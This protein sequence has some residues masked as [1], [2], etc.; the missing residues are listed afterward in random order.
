MIHEIRLLKI[1]ST[2]AAAYIICQ[3]KDYVPQEMA[4]MEN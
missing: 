3:Y 4:I 1:H 2:V